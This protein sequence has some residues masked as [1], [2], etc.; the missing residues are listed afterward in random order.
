MPVEN[1]SET[2]AVVHLC[3]EPQFTEDMESLDKAL[4]H[5][6]RH[7]LLDLAA[8]HYVNSSNIAQL[9]RLRKEMIT[10]NRRLALC[11]L[12]TPVWGAFL[13]TGLDKIF[14]F[15]DDV[16]TGLA[17]LQIPGDAR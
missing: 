13:V 14:D 5:R 17:M 10:G 15:A 1:W 16:P 8:V 9:L 6:S 4:K 2:V 7:V 11:G 12:I 3:D